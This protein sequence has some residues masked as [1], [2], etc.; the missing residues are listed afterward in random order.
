M[1]TIKLTII[2]LSLALT[3]NAQKTSTY[4][5]AMTKGIALL[6]SAKTPEQYFQ[7]ANYF[8]RVASVER[9]Q[10]L[11]AYYAGYSHLLAGIV[12]KQS[13]EEKDALYD[14]AM[15]EADQ[16]GNISASNSE[17]EVLK[18][19]I[20]FMKMSLD[21]SQRAMAMLPKADA[22]LANAIKLDPDN[23]RAY[24][25]RGQDTFYSPEA[26]GGG[27]DK[28]KSLLLIASDKFAKASPAVFA[29]AWGK[30]NCVDLLKR[31]N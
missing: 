25:I 17:I 7:A 5:T 26:F 8:N 3:V 12:G 19:Y 13:N 10:W 6:D 20:T 28:A 27:K 14:Q 2:I 9:Q 1:K 31:C 24:Y 29:P 4:T 30:G 21:P 11:P 15:V 23:P 18:G 16:A 22:I